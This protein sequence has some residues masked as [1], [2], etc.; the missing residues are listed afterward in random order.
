MGISHPDKEDNTI[1]NPGDVSI[2]QMV[3][4][5]LGLLDRCRSNSGMQDKHLRVLQ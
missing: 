5:E 4:G 1:G 3:D 2:Y